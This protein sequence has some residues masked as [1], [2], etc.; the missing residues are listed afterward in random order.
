MAITAGSK[1]ARHSP[2]PTPHRRGNPCGG[3]IGV[4]FH[5]P[6]RHQ[7]HP[8]TDIPPVG[9][10]CGPGGVTP[11]ERCNEAFWVRGSDAVTEAGC[12][13]NSWNVALGEA[14]LLVSYASLVRELDHIP[15]VAGLKLISKQSTNTIS[16]AWPTGSKIRS[17]ML[18]GGGNVV[19]L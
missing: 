13:P 9:P 5:I 10:H 6:G 7:A 18:V 16:L 14:D 2:H 4:D 1:S 3:P 8:Y 19:S 12:T 15:V 17:A 11:Q